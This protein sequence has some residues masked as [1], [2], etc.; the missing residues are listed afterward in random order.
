MIL[1]AILL[2]GEHNA[3]DVSIKTRQNSLWGSLKAVPLSV[4]AHFWRPEGKRYLC[5]RDLFA[6]Y[7]YSCRISQGEV[8]IVF[9]R[10]LVEA[11]V[12]NLTPFTPSPL[13]ILFHSLIHSFIYSATQNEINANISVYYSR[14]KPRLNFL[15]V[16]RW[17]P[18]MLSVHS[19]RL[20]WITEVH[21]GK[22]EEGNSRRM[23][24]QWG[25]GRD[26]ATMKSHCNVTYPPP[27]HGLYVSEARGE[28]ISTRY[29]SLWF[30]SW[31]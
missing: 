12:T 9:N 7:A 2:R 13:H 6:A 8:P 22:W 19:R 10:R 4:S 18:L 21:C 23:L 20:G 17:C 14:S 28:V 27:L 29:L 25:L 1:F 24:V 16:S 11:N 30:N 5:K 3:C 26:T 15:F 31:S